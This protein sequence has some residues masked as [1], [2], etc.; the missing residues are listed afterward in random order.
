MSTADPVATE[1]NL[2]LLSALAASEARFHRLVQNSPD[3]III[4]NHKGR[5][6]YV[7]SEASSMFGRSV[8]NLTG[9]FFG[10][11]I[12]KGKSTEIEVLGPDKK[13]KVAEMRVAEIQWE[14]ESAFMCSIRDLS[15]RAR[16]MEDLKRSNE[17]LNK[18]AEVISQNIRTP[19][20]NIGLLASWLKENNTAAMNADATEDLQLIIDQAVH[21]QHMLEDLLKYNQASSNHK[22]SA[23]VNLQDVLN[24]AIESLSSDIFRSGAEIERCQLPKLNCNFDQMVTVFQHLLS[25]A[26]NYCEG[27]PKVKID[28]ERNSD[29]WTISIKDNGVGIDVKNWQNVF[30]PFNQLQKKKGQDSTGIGLATCKK[31]IERHNGQIGLTSSVSAGTTIFI[32]MPIDKDSKPT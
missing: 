26:I 19:L 25:N 15:T 17:D 1:T 21:A 29:F 32:Q 13:P 31:I 23:D 14:G 6:V 9:K 10:C 22:R 18:F 3:G 28:C 8:E 24:E 11:P 27:K 12:S 7:N 16:L 4:S 20:Q 5:I 30:L 2:S